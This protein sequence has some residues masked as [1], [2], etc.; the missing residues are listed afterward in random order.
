MG[1]ARRSGH[2]LSG[3]LPRS[4][5]ARSSLDVAPDLLGR[6]VLAGGPDGVVRVRLVEVE[7]YLGSEDPGSH[8]FRGRTQRNATM[9][10]PPGHLYV[11]FTYGMHWCMNVVCAAAGVP[12][13]VL[14]RA[15]VLLEG[16]DIAVER[17]HGSPARDLARGPARLAQALGV[18]RAWDGIDLIA[19][20]LQL[21]AGEP[22]DAAAIRTGPRVGVSG[23]GAVAPWRFWIDGVPEVSAYR[24]AVRRK[25]SAG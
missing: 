18:D 3:S 20:P 15:A 12:E 6:D 19:G 22:P 24:P 4:F 7:A 13:A 11:Y 1:Q 25:R 14:L 5:Y 16:A 21:L 2:R 17:R 10:G 8:A 23:A 9:F